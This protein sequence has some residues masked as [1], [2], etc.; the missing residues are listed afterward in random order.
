MTITYLK[1][2]A[3]T[4]E[5]ETATAQQVVTEMLAA[6]ESGGE[7]AVR[8]YALKLDKWSGD[9]VL[10]AAQIDAAIADVPAQVRADI[11]FAV[12]QITDFA[13]AQKASIVD[14]TVP[15]HAGVTSALMG[16]GQMLCMALSSVVVAALASPNEQDAP[17]STP[18]PAAYVQV[19]VV[20]S[21]MPQTGRFSRHARGTNSCTKNSASLR[22][23]GDGNSAVHSR[24]S[25]SWHN[26]KMRSMSTSDGLVK[27]TTPSVRSH[28][29]TS[30]LA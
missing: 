25:E 7:Q 30:P 3:K 18:A 19:V 17:A 4:P 11:D 22:V 2:A 16:C 23:Y 13:L 10:T 21:R 1:K 8:D 5:T 20:A 15:L 9:I 27:N 12:R 26:S 24:I 29:S 28:W 14:V 6:I